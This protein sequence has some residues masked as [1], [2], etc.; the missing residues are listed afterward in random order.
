MSNRIRRGIRVCPVC[1]SGRLL[2]H[3][4]AYRPFR[5]LRCALC[6]NRVLDEWEPAPGT[7]EFE[8]VDFGDYV[9]SVGRQRED[10]ARRILATLR[11]LVPDRGALLDIGCSFGWFLVQAQADGWQAHGIEPSAIASRQALKAGLRV[12]QGRFRE[13]R[14]DGVE[15]DVACL[16][17]V[18][19]HIGDPAAFLDHVAGVL[20]PEGL[21]V[22]QVPNAKGLVL[23][24]L[25]QVARIWPARAESSIRRLYQLD[26]P[27]PHLNFFTPASL[28]ALLRRH[29][30]EPVH[31]DLW[32]VFSG[33]I[34]ERLAY[35]GTQR[36][37]WF[38]VG[39]AWSVSRLAH[40]LRR[41]DIVFLIARK[42]GR[43]HPPYR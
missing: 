30:F 6:A 38:D 7:D 1:G 27:F 28:A 34:R 41:D 42:R 5:V 9:R 21:L 37:S 22:L 33:P 23:W 36:V 31:Q 40:L 12:L 35:S 26:F 4:T 24:F 11:D 19:E 13:N 32:P 10:A 14:F 20:R 3:L 8:R 2:P 17:D 15:F 39:A 29:S 16:L 25:E 18:L 43:L